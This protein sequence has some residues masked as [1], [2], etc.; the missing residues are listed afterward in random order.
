MCS[1]FGPAGGRP[2]LHRS[3]AYGG[4]AALRF[5]LRYAEFLRVPIKATIWYL[6]AHPRLGRL[7]F[8]VQ[9]SKYRMEP[10]T[11]DYDVA[12]NLVAAIH[13]LQDTSS[14]NLTTEKVPTTSMKKQSFAQLLRN[15]AAARAKDAL[16][17]V[18]DSSKIYMEFPGTQPAL[19]HLNCPVW[20]DYKKT[21]QQ[22]DNLPELQRYYHQRNGWEDAIFWTID[23]EVYASTYQSLSKSVQHFLGQA[24]CRWLPTNHR[25]AKTNLQTTNKC[26]F[27]GAIETQDHLLRCNSTDWKG[28]FMHRLQQH[29][30]SSKMIEH[31]QTQ[32]W[33][34]TQAWLNEEPSNTTLSEQD[35][36]GWSHIFT[37]KLGKSWRN[38]ATISL[39]QITA[40]A[41]FL[42][43]EFHELWKQRCTTQ[44]NN[45]MSTTNF[46]RREVELQLR[47]LYDASKGLLATDRIPFDTPLE[48]V[49]TRNTRDL[50][51]TKTLLENRLR[52][53]LVIA[54][55]QSTL[56]T[57][58]IR[59]YFKNKTP[60][61]TQRPH[62]TES[63]AHALEYTD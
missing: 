8:Q 4:A 51:I 47:S 60:H 46:K 24:N 57:N 16:V 14:F 49:L 54:H 13:S 56:Q 62:L 50:L 42:I 44:H 9:N 17:P 36:I 48:E 10:S 25:L 52:K 20:Q 7:L 26:Q 41:T 22:Y 5:L 38:P 61:P 58:D 1:G 34:G 28:N 21:L 37:G 12:Y 35:G 45:P 55:K 31:Q 11:D 29:L 15:T 40:L 23:W 18:N 19:Y 30:I 2:S 33:Q 6:C 59:K 3:T 43:I 27:C 39:K 63:V 32:F 53:G